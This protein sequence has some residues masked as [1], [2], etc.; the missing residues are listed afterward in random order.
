[1]LEP[2]LF[3]QYTVQMG[4][5]CR[6]HGVMYH[7]YADDSRVD[8]EVDQET[9]Q[10]ARCRIQHT[11]LHCGHTSLDGH[12]AQT[13]RTTEPASPAFQAEEDSPNQKPL[14]IV[15]YTTLSRE[16]D[17]IQTGLL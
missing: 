5:I 9:A 13:Q 2:I 1:M 3:N 14:I 8:S 15:D 16:L 17:Y 6:H 12:R 4:V 11:S 10:S 7:L